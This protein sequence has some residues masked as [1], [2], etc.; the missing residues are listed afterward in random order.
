MALFAVH[1]RIRKSAKMSGSYPCLWIHQN[2][3]V[4]T[5]IVRAFLN[6]FLPPCSFYIIFQ[7]HTKISIIPCICKSTVNLRSRIYESSGF[8]QCY[9]FFH[10]LFHDMSS[11]FHLFLGA[12]RLCHFANPNLSSSCTSADIITDT[13]HIPTRIH[14]YPAVSV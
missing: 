9:N 14:L 1:Q 6:E 4:N 11:F 8:C 10:C 3:T 13:V 12:K 2:R 5:Y 7:F